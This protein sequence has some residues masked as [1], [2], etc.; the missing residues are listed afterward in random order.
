MS[1]DSDKN[2]E[3]GIQLSSEQQRRRRSRS[4]ALALI[5]GGLVAFFYIVTV[6]KIGSNV[7]NRAL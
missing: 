1:E 4:V 3:K 5:L 6:A 7:L 2:Q